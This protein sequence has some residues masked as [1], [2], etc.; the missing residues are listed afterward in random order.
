MSSELAKKLRLNH[1][2][3]ACILGAPEGYL[4]KLNP[5]PESVDVTQQAQ[6]AKAYDF[7][8]LFVRSIAEVESLAPQAIAAVT[9]EGML[10]LVYPKQSGKIKTDIN[11]DAGWE[12]VK[13]LGFEGVALISIDETWSSMRFRPSKQVKSPRSARIAATGSAVKTS[14]TQADRVIVV[15]DDLMEAFKN[16]PAAASFFDSLA[17]TH[18]KEYVRWI[19]DAKRE[20]TRNARVAKT[21]DKLERGI[22]NPTI[23]EQ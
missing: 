9:D 6:S 11:R 7:V 5:L 8:Q 17:Y 18:R 22:K 12:T 10:W 1:C 21:V 20:E 14:S 19:T 13:K 16:S 2:K 4:D 3:H 15:P 23:K